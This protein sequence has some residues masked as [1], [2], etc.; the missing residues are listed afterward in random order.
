MSAGTRPGADRSPYHLGERIDQVVAGHARRTPD[1]LA[2][3]QGDETVS[4][5]EL[6]ARARSVAAGL[7]ARGIGPGDF[8]PVLIERSPELVAVLLGVLTAGAAYIAMDPA[9]P[10]E[11]TAD[12]VRRSDARLVVVD[13]PRPEA[14]AGAGAIVPSEELRGPEAGSVAHTDGTAAACVFYTSGSTGRPKGVVSPHRGTIR[15]LVG[16]P[17]IPLDATTVFL[18]AAPLPW[19]AF[20]LELWA[21]LLNGG[22]CVLLDRGVPALDADG[23]RRALA[24]GVDSMWLTSSLFTVLLE[25]APEEFGRLRLLLVG[26]ERVSVRHAREALT[27][28]PGLRLVNGYGPA[29]STIFATTHAIGPADVAEDSTDIPIGRPVPCTGAVL[30]GPDGTVLTGPATGELALSG[31]GLAAGY[32]GDAAETARRFVLL[33]GVRHYRTGDVAGR[34]A[35]GLL[36]HRGRTDRQVKLRGV[37]IEPG[38][39]ETVL[40]THPAVTSCLVFLVEPV[41]GRPELAAL[42]T[43]AT[44]APVPGP[45]LRR[46]AAH[47]LLGAMVPTRLVHTERL[48]LGPT[49]K[50][51]QSAAAAIVLA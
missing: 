24:A 38:E 22:R 12:V 7:R 18:Q 27:R 13:R 25:E 32:L 6:L 26:G 49:G 35:D 17:T 8:V 47:R 1:A 4:Y 28:F 41:P 15:T 20:A 39:V 21:P 16:C 30:L 37:R 40:E 43:T 45:E 29:E 48:P 42:Y 3:R 2:L 51:D 10:A 14:G 33:D 36:R 9:W 31:D 50:A 11:R 23:L 46:T 5:G 34:D 44:G 19:D